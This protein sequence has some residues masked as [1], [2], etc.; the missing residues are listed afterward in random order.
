MAESK[1][2]TFLRESSVTIFALSMVGGAGWIIT[3]QSESNV[4]LAIISTQITGMEK[5]VVAVRTKMGDDK[6]D[7]RSELAELKARIVVL[8]A[9]HR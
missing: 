7:L 8:E 2:L 5:E 6:T 4:K 9:N 3:N 1:I